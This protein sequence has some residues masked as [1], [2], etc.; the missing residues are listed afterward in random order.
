MF[1]KLTLAFVG[2]IFIILMLE[3]LVAYVISADDERREYNKWKRHLLDEYCSR[4]DE[5][6][7]KE[8]EAE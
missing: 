6:L 1:L 7:D 2:V 5:E 4:I 3:L 8:E